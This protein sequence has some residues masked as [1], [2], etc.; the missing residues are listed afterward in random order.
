[1]NNVI[2]VGNMTKD[3]EGRKVSDNDVLNFTVAVP[4]QYKNSAGEKE[5]DFIDCVAWGHTARYLTSFGA[6]GRKVAV[7][8]ELQKR[9]YEK[10][11]AKV[12]VTEVRV[13]NAELIGGK[14]EA[15]TE[16]QGNAFVEV[17]EKLPWEE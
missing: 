6:K 9:S 14:A 4:R 13:N 12:W 1:M 3:P 16:A 2:L 15:Q 11:G 17:D 5:T 8:G 10:D 7:S